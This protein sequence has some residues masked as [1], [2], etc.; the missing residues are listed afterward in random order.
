MRLACALV[1]IQ[2]GATCSTHLR[3]PNQANLT[4]GK[5]ILTPRMLKNATRALI[6]ATALLAVAAC[7][8][9]TSLAPGLTQQMDQPGATL[10][11][12][13]ALTLL[14][15]YRTNEG[16]APFVL[17]AQLSADAQSLA[18]TYAQSGTPPRTASKE[19][20]F[21]TSAG[22]TRFADVF[23]GWR[24]SAPDA[25]VL[26]DP[27]RKSIGLGVSSD[28]NSAYGVHWVLLMR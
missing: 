27:S 14:N 15:H 1:R 23:S 22:Y 8:T 11:R 4:K 16:A 6:A 10:D 25:R 2:K 28:A 24:N 3:G 19:V 21:L 12:A 7:S 13:A 17:D 26:A 18:Q 9:D 5:K 20:T